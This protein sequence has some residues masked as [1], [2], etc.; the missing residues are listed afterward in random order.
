MSALKKIFQV[1]GIKLSLVQYF[2]VLL[3]GISIFTFDIDISALF[4]IAVGYFL[5]GGIGFSMMLHRYYTHRSFEFKSKIIYYIFEFVSI[6]SLRGSI[7]GWAYVHR[8]HH[9]NTDTKD[10]P[11]S[12]FHKKWKVLFPSFMKYDK[13]FNKFL[14]KDL[15]ND[16]QI[17]INNFYFLI[18][19]LWSLFLIIIDYHLFLYF[20]VIPVSL[21]HIILMAFI[22][23]GHSN[24]QKE[25]M[26]KDNIF[27]G[28]F[29][30]GEGWHV[31]HHENPQNHRFVSNKFNIDIIDVLIKMIK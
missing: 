25:E 1:T 19:I 17:F 6:I 27:F 14:V 16:R 20:Y 21:L 11:H 28:I 23:F 2:C 7:L 26:I 3:S 5:Y 24:E 12:P 22:Y 30:F 8:K 10:D 18:I 31:N 4:L 9:K 15:L 29:L 13:N